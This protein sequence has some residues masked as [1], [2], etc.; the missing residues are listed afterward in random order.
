M[1]HPDRD[2]PSADNRTYTAAAHRRPTDPHGNPRPPAARP[3]LDRLQSST[4]L[5][6]SSRGLIVREA[7]QHGARL[8]LRLEAQQ[9]GRRR[10]SSHPRLEPV[11]L[12]APQCIARTALWD[13][14]QSVHDTA[15]HATARHLQMQGMVWEVIGH[16]QPECRN[17]NEAP[18][19]G[20]DRAHNRSGHFTLF[21]NNLQS[22]R[23]RVWQQ[24]WVRD[25]CTSGRGHKIASKGRAG[26]CTRGRG[27]GGGASAGAALPTCR[28]CR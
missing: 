5:L 27:G 7:R 19:V 20:A 17:C 24:A 25:L 13:R 12:P 22:T 9:A 14:R 4:E 3:A 28:P 8:V 23:K 21:P 2:S 11:G 26:A 10:S 18:V 1:K 6:A 15:A 16:L